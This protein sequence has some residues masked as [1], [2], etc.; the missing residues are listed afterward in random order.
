MCVD[1]CWVTLLA[2]CY[3][4]GGETQRARAGTAPYVEYAA[5]P[6]DLKILLEPRQQSLSDVLA[7]PVH[8]LVGGVRGEVP[9]LP[10]V[11]L[12]PVPSQ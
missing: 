8:A 2:A 12:V 1:S 3:D 4:D 9:K 6:L 10:V 5:A 7:E 11:V